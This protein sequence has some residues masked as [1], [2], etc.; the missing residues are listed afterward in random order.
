M[1]RKT[2]STLLQELAPIWLAD[3]RM[4]VKESTYTRYYRNVYRYLLPHLGETPVYKLNTLQV[5]GYADFLL[6]QGGIR[7]SGL[8]PKTVSDILSTL[9]TVLQYG[10]ICGYPCAPARGIRLP[11]SYRQTVTL[12]PDSRAL[13]EKL[14]LSRNDTTSIGIM[15]SLFAGLRI[16]ELCGLRWEDIDLKNKTLTV[17]RTVERIADLNASYNRTKLIISEPKTANSYRQ[18]P[19]PHFLTE[20]LGMLTPVEGAYL[21]SGSDSPIEPCTFY[22]RYRRF[23]TV[24]GLPAYRFHALRH[25]FATRCVEVGFDTKALSEIMGH[26][27]VATTMAIYVH[28]PMAQ[29][30]RYMEKLAPNFAH[31]K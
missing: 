30:R 10:Q 4:R 19:L 28:P 17:S 3:V 1:Q 2:R 14:I 8:A 6:S 12:P 9:N 20:R 23:L 11:G 7:G 18:I 16:G 15:L 24:N 25:T 29:K 13:L 26:A 21:L 22:K 27:N 31:K 5:S